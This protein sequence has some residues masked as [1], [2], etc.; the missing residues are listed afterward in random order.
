MIAPVVRGERVLLR[1]LAV[2]DAPLLVSWLADPEV[3]REIEKEP[4]TLADEEAFILRVARSDDLLAA[5][6][7]H[8]GALV[9]WIDLSLDESR[10]SASFG[11]VVGARALWGRGIGTEATRL[12]LRIAFESLGLARVTLTV[13]VT[14]E[15]GIRAYERAGFRR[16]SVR[17]RAALVDGA[18]VD[19]LAMEIAREDYTSRTK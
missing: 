4:V 19:E 18:L 7:E 10:E 6:I 2:A 15:R 16:E 3:T 1:P 5:G 14:N 9:G 12:A 8:A 17:E 11:I 13:N